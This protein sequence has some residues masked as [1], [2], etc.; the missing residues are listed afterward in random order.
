MA[1]S[2]LLALLQETALERYLRE[3]DPRTRAAIRAELRISPAEAE[4]AIREGRPAPA[5]GAAPG[6]TVRRKTVADHPLAVPFEY[7]LRVP[8]R[9]APDRRWPLLVLL[10]GQGGSGEDALRRWLPQAGLL[11]DWFLLAPTAGRGGW[12]RSLLG[13][14][15]VFTALREAAASYALDPDRI[16]LDGASMGGNGAFQLIGAYPDRFAAGAVR[17]GGPAFRRTAAAPEAPVEAE[18]LEN[19]LATPIYWIV[20]A[21][22]PK[23]PNAWVRQARAR[24]E[25]LGAPIVFREYPEGGHE[26]FPQENGP[27]LEW[28]SGRRRDAYPSRVGL[29][30]AERLF[31]RAYW[32]EIAAFRGA[33]R[34]ERNFTDSEGK[35]LETR[36]VLPEEARVSA[37]L[38]RESNEIRVTASG[39][40]ELRI[41]LHESMVDFARPVVVTANGARSSFT[42]RPSLEILLESARR[43]RGLLYTAAL[44]LR[45]P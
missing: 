24:L 6:E 22:D 29:A 43:D 13:H 26:A 28:M 27:V 35:V 25:A 18:G 36:R 30:S 21:R 14:A 12:G 4:R 9:Y 10:H 37:E 44:T 31:N 32:L 23:L 1:A 16:F 41:Y 34:V 2:I 7:L 45:V 17:S 5:G 19:F 8:A 3:P 15:Y 11:E 40:K 20:G 39:V 33:E 38:R 42:A